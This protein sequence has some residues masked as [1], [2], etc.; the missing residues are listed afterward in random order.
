MLR[1]TFKIGVLSMTFILTLNILMCE[2]ANT[3]SYCAE[4]KQVMTVNEDWFIKDLE[5]KL[6][7]KEQKF[8]YETSKKYE[9]DPLLIMAIMCVE[10]GF[11]K[12]A[13]SE[14]NDV[15]ICQINRSNLKY[16]EKTLGRDIDLFNFE[17]NVECSLIIIS[18]AY[19]AWQKYEK[20]DGEKQMYLAVA[21]YNRGV[22]G[23][24]K[25]IVSRG[26]DIKKV[27]YAVMVVST[28]TEYLDGNFSYNPRD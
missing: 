11:N 3:R 5:E 17:D 25:Q 8:V 6:S 16:L 18:D 7:R 22:S 26:K 12:K 15:G 23:V 19:R 24:N 13:K 21:S 1:E 9:I 4:K 2:G 20:I 10:S 28:Y 27:D 14:T